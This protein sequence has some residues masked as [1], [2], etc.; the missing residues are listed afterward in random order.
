MAGWRK[1]RPEVVRPSS[2]PCAPTAGIDD[3]K[4]TEGHTCG[5]NFGGY[6]HAQYLV[7]LVQAG[8]TEKDIKPTQFA[9]GA[10][11]AAAFNSGR[12]DVYSGAH[13]AILSA[14]SPRATPRSSLTDERHR[15]PCAQRL[16][17]PHATCST[18]TA[19]DKA[20]EDFFGRRL[21]LL[22][23][24]RRQRRR[25]QGRSS[26]S[27]SRSTT[28]APTSSTRCAGAS[29][30]R[31]RRRTCWH[32]SRPW[33]RAL[34]DGDGHPEAAERRH[35]V[36]PALQR[37]PEGG[38]RPRTAGRVTIDCPSRRRLGGPSSTTSTQVVEEVRRRAATGVT[39]SA[40]YALDEIERLREIGF[41]PLTVPTRARRARARP[42]HGRPGDPAPGRGRRQPGPDPA[43]PLHD[44]RADPAHRHPRRSGRTGSASWRRGAFFGNASA[45]PGERPPGESAT[46]L[47]RDGLGWLLEGRKVYSHRRP[48]GRP[49]RRPGPRPAG[50]ATHVLVDAGRTRRRHPRRLGEPRP[51]DHG[52]RRLGVR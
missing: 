32:R 42:G 49:R 34:F 47:R 45:E 13:G 44:R 4:R 1:V 48:A 31:V 22:G 11:S 30:P 14:R 3:I 7:S 6:N 20:L 8:L 35:R 24:A 39:G 17:R 21:G 36:R 15:D 9:D 43:E 5:F 28:R 16:D 50:R 38:S 12:V 37:R 46:A 51:A 29:L 19:K 27:S 10:T 40:A 23:L 26:R 52:L 33:R 18:T 25:G 2:P 41:W